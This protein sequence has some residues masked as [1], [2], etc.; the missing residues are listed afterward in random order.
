MCVDIFYALAIIAFAIYFFVLLVIAV[1]T[2]KTL[3][4]IASGAF[5]G[6]AALTLVDI[7]SVFT[8]VFIPLNMWTVGSS[9]AFGIPGVIS[10]LWLNKIIL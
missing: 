9:A 8:G 3:K 4:T 5:S 1:K 7:T 2:Q 10:L 6:I